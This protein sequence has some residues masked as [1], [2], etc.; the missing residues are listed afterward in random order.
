MAE[1]KEMLEG[2]GFAS[3]SF[4]QTISGDPRELTEIEPAKEG[5]GEGVFCVGKAVK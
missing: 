3:T 5:F 2:A 1:V 4:I